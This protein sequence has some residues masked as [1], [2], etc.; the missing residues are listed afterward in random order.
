VESADTVSVYYKQYLLDEDG[1]ER[2]AKPY[3]LIE[4]IY[5]QSGTNELSEIFNGKAKFKFPKPS[6]LIQLLLQPFV[7]QDDV[8][9]DCCGGSGTTGH[10]VMKLNREDGGDRKFI[11]VQQPHDTKQHEADNLNIC[12]EVTAERLRRVITGYSFTKKTRTKRRKVTVEG[13]GDTFT[14]ARVGDPLFGEYKNWK[15]NAPEFEELAQYVFYTETS[16]DCDPKKFKKRS[17][18]IGATEAAGGTSYYLLYTPNDKAD[19]EL[20]LDTLAKLAETDE[21]R[22][23][24]IYC[25]KIWLHQDQLRAFEREHGKRVRPMLV[26]FNL[27]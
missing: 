5:T 3:S 24:V 2:G 23:W 12:K 4:G 26:P 19:K 21:N 10:A 7:D 11:V 27:K 20:S 14:Y 18:F 6:D 13:F 15:S 16:R 25:E 17:G 22:N 1:V 8:V 9:L